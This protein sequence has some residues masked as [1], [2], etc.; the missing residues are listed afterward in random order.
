MNPVAEELSEITKYYILAK[1]ATFLYLLDDIVVDDE[2][3][4]PSTFLQQTVKLL[5]VI[6]KVVLPEVSKQNDL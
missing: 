3:S 2:W 6:C 1:L 4:I 5:E